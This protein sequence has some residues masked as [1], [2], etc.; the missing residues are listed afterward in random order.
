MLTHLSISNVVLIDKLDLDFSEGLTILSGETGAGKSILLDSLG[1]VLGSRGD[2][3]LIRTG[4]D[5]LS[6]T[7]VFE[8]RDQNS[9]FYSI[10]RDNDLE[11]DGDIIIKRSLQ[12]DGRGKI[13]INDQPISLKLLKE[14]SPFLVEVHG[15]FDN[16]GLLNPLTHRI[17]L[18][19]YGS[20]QEKLEKVKQAF[21][22]YRQTEKDLCLASQALQQ[23][24]SQEETLIHFKNELE[25][26]KLKK[27]EEQEIVSKRNEM[28]HAEKILDNFSAAH[29]ALQGEA[30]AA[31]VRHAMSAVSKVNQLTNDK[32]QNIFEFLDAALVNLDEATLAI[33]SASAEI[34]LNSNDL[35]A[36]EE[37][38][39]ALK[40]LARKHQ[41]AIDDLPDVLFNINQK[42]KMIEKNADDV[43][44]LQKNLNEAKKQYVQE[45]TELHDLREKAALDLSQKVQN[46]L[47]FLKMKQ[48]KFKIQ[49]NTLEEEKWTETGFDDVTFL[50]ST[51]LGQPFALLSKIA[52]GGELS[53][54]MLALKLNLSG[55]SGVETLIFDEIDSGVGGGTAEAIGNRLLKLSKDV[56]V[57]VVTHL[58]Q[59]ASFSKTHFKIEKETN[60]GQTTTKVKCL[61]D[62]EKKEEIARMLSGEKISD[63]ARL[64]AKVLIESGRTA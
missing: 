45:S 44:L 37:R 50:A 47:Q 7:G 60:N 27:G 46:E 64:A 25:G 11:I 57:F 1:L 18:D 3:G 38:F 34:E 62:I 52:S 63:E 26:M 24:E 23:A 49:I 31:N 15:Q 33:E 32:Y 22:T 12:K 8:L 56:Q 58:P 13:F 16:Q 53:R 29:E 51:N 40:S 9:P 36:L 48:A 2:I 5:K 19:S 41:C 61:S 42:L 4:T 55:Q 54:F 59:V 21:K 17:L 6:V 20:Y 14:L 10:A 43:I 28:M 39:F 30:F 35:N